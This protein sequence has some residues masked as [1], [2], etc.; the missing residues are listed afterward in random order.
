MV[1]DI[2]THQTNLATLPLSGWKIRAFITNNKQQKGRILILNITVLKSE[3][4]SSIL[5]VNASFGV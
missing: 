2:F 3:A 1:A 4:K 5:T